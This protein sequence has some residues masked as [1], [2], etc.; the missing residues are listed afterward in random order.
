M[1]T[2]PLLP[3]PTVATAVRVGL[4]AVAAARIARGATRPAPLGAA[5]R[6]EMIGRLDAASGATE[7]EPL[8][9]IIDSERV[10]L[11]DAE[12]GKNI[13]LDHDPQT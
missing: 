1:C 9:M 5:E 13:G 8:D 2:V 6:A 4:V 10:V 7:G 3:R 11:F 12:S